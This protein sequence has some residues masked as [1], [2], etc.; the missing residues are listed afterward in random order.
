MTRFIGHHNFAAFLN[1]ICIMETKT[2][3]PGLQTVHFEK[4]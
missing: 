3:L 2:F 1:G 4:R